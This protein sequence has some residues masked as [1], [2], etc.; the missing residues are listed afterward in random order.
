MPIGRF[1][2][3]RSIPALNQF[4]GVDRRMTVVGK[5]NGATIVDDYGHHP[6]EI[7]VTLKALREKY[8]PRRLICVF[9]PH[10]HSRTRHLLE[11]FAAIPYRK[12]NLNYWP[13]VED[14]FAGETSR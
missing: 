8:N 13:R 9:Q 1:T 11:D 6:T 14:P 3:E 10:Q 2:T 12:R 5:V 4:T 7:R